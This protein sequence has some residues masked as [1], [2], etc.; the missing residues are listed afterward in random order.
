MNHQ[1]Y[2]SASWFL[3]IILNDREWDTLTYE[4]QLEAQQ[5]YERCILDQDCI[6]AALIECVQA[7][8][9]LIQIQTNPVYIKHLDLLI[10]HFE[11]VLLEE[12]FAGTA[13]LLDAWYSAPR[14]WFAG[15]KM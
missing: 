1:P 11:L 8:E 15:R 13:Y 4:Q 5:L 14:Q 9:A 6:R 12:K 10:E 7:R 2:I 3:P